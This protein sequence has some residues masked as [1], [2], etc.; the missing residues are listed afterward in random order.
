[1]FGDVPTGMRFKIN[2]YFSPGS[3]LFYLR[4]SAKICVPIHLCIVISMR[5]RA[6]KGSNVPENALRHFDLLPGADSSRHGQGPENKVG[7]STRSRFINPPSSAN[8]HVHCVFHLMEN[9]VKCR[10]HSDK[11]APP[12]D[13]F[14][15]KQSAAIF[16]LKLLTL[17]ALSRKPTLG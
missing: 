6:E 13:F 1:M 12:S 4:V 11:F 3:P 10:G 2:T 9:D 8:F 14:D 5:G 16:G 17:K 15:L 7:D